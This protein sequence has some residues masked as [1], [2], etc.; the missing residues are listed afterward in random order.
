ML[1]VATLLLAA[2]GSSRLGQPKQLLPF[3]N[4]TLLR[5][6][7]ETALEAALGPVIVVLGAVEE[8][9]RETLAGLAVTVLANPAWEE[10]MGTSIAIGMQAVSDALHRAVIVM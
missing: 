6:A 7:A 10:G 3:G 1:P 5:H 9:C 2:G 8:K 4:G